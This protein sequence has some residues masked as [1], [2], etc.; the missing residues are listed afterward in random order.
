MHLACRCSCPDRRPAN[1]CG[2][3]R[4]REDTSA[5]IVLHL[6]LIDAEAGEPKGIVQ[7]DIPR[8]AFVD[9][10]LHFPK[11]RIGMAGGRFRWPEIG[12]YTVTVS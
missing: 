6:A 11:R 3:H 9:E 4:R 8:P 1:G 12:D 5:L 10:G 2:R 7:A